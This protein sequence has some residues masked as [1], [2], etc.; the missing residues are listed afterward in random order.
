[1]EDKKEDNIIDD[2]KDNNEDNFIDDVE[3]KK[4]LTTRRYSLEEHPTS[5]N[6][7]R[8]VE[9]IEIVAKTITKWCQ[10]SFVSSSK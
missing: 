5:L 4:W 7:N 6:E 9:T 8:K 3:E 10:R 2:V 1:M